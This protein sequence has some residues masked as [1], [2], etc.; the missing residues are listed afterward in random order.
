KMIKY[1]LCNCDKEAWEEIVVQ[2]DNHYNYE[3]VI[4]FHCSDC[5][6]DF[7]VE[8]FETGEAY[9]IGTWE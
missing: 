2:K 1:K 4:Y 9:A 6:E 7:R 8:N 3:N 5:G